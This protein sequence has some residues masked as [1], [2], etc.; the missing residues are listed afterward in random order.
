MDKIREIIVGIVVPSRYK[1]V[2]DKISKDNQRFSIIWSIAELAYWTMSI[3]MS[4]FN[5]LYRMCRNVYIVSFIICA[6]SLVASLTIA[7]KYNIVS[8]ITSIILK[9]VILGAGIG[10]AIC[11]DAR[12]IVIFIS[13]ILTPIMFIS[14]INL[15]IVLAFIHIVSFAITG[16]IWMSAEVYSWTLTNM[17]IFSTLGV[18]VAH[19]INK[20]RLESYLYMESATKLA[21]V[22]TKYAYYDQ[23]TNL[24]NR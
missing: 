20:A 7:K 3:F 10:I 24:R 9:L 13:T 1:D 12:T 15:N 16:N 4:F 18:M 19:F 5:E 22:Q 23:L 2:T 21:E 14:S 11:Q 6:I 17:C 8:Y